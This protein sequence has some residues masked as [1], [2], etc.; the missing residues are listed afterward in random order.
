MT[1]ASVRSVLDKL[2]F[3]HGRGGSSTFRSFTCG[4]AGD[5][6]VRRFSGGGGWLAGCPARVDVSV[7]VADAVAD[8][9]LLL[10]TRPPR[11][12]AS[13]ELPL[14]AQA[15]RWARSLLDTKRL[16]WMS[17]PPN[18]LAWEDAT[19]IASELVTNA[20]EHA[21][22]TS[23]IH[24]ALDRLGVHIAVRD[25]RPGGVARPGQPVPSPSPTRRGH[26]L[27]LVEQLSRSW[28]VTAHDDGKTVWAIIDTASGD[29][30]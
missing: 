30:P 22:T 7:L 11:V 9:G 13:R 25:H 21:R 14:S 23:T 24:V 1:V 20:V 4:A 18:E 12:S 15:P 8:A 28:G 29:T 10:Q 26:G 19:L 6:V 2:L 17:A 16:D 3:D 27:V 5:R